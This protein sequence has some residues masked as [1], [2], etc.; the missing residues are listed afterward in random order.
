VCPIG[1][2]ILHVV[3]RNP[4]DSDDPNLEA[5]GPGFAAAQFENLDVVEALGLALRSQLHP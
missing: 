3:F 5:S 2:R 4:Q 1:R